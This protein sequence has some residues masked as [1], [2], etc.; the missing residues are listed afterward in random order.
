MSSQAARATTPTSIDSRVSAAQHSA[1]LTHPSRRA[2]QHSRPPPRNANTASPGVKLMIART[3][4][5]TTS[6]AHHGLTRRRNSSN[7]I[8]HVAADPEA[9]ASAASTHGTSWGWP[10]D[11]THA[12]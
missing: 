3:P 6:R 2:V 7:A 1:A 11:P 9:V 12:K 8:T 10:R 5:R 4:T